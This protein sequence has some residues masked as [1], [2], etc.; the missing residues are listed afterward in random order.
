MDRAGPE[1]LGACG[2]FYVKKN[3][4]L[5]GYE[6]GHSVYSIF[7]ADPDQILDQIWSRII[8]PSPTYRHTMFISLLSITKTLIIYTKIKNR[9]KI[10]LLVIPD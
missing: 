9:L 5:S 10:N 8:I 3:V 7:R 2:C 4:L 6:S 1:I